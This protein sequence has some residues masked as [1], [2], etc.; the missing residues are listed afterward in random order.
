MEENVKLLDQT[1]LFSGLHPKHR[2]QIAS[3]LQPAQFPAGETVFS[4]GDPGDA[5][6][7]VKAGE[8]VVHVTNPEV[9]IHFELARLGPGQVFGEMALLTEQPRGATVRASSDTTCLVLA[10]EVFVRVCQQL[11]DVTL[12]VAKTMA[13]RLDA[14]NR[15]QGISF[16]SLANLSVDPEA[17]ALVPTQILQRHKMIPLKMDGNMLTMAM[18]DPSNVM[19]F[20]DVRRC[21]HGVNVKPVAISEEDYSS[22]F[23]R[24]IRPSMV[25]AAPGSSDAPGSGWREL[26]IFSA[27]AVGEE[28]K[29]A[30]SGVT[31]QEIVALV[32][33]IMAE[34]IDREASDVHIDC[35]KLNVHVR[36]RVDG[37]LV[38]REQ[39][40]PRSHYR[41]LISRIKI[42]SGMDIADQRLPQDGRISLT[43]R[44]R[45]FDVRVAS[46]PV[47]G[48]ERIAMRLLDAGSSI[49]E[50]GN[51]ILAEKLAQ[52][53]RRMAFRPTGAVLVTGPT[54]SGKTT[55]LYS[56]LRERTRYA[57]DMNIVTVEDPIEYDL[58]GMAQ[59]QVKETSGLTFPV[60][61]RGF[62]R[63]DPDIIMVGETRD[64]TTA[65]IAMEASITG[66]LVLT[67]MHT[68]SALG[69][70]VRLREMGIE[71]YLIA[72]ALSGV[73]AQR[74][75]RRVCP[76][77]SEKATY[78]DS[79]LENLY[80]C[81]VL[82]EGEQVQMV[83]EGGCDNCDQ[84][85]FRG[86]VGV[87]E[88]LQ[89]GES[90][91][92]LVA[93]EAPMEQLRKAAEA[94]GMVT[95]PRYAGFL[96]KH[97]LTV[98]SEVLRILATDA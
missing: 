12:A 45:D 58:P 92:T 29:R 94:Q 93:G 41:P 15:E 77:C 20:D 37:Q 84:T 76:M 9:G 89:M 27:Q 39:A 53:V 95:M 74:L 44:K 42:L 73:I 40:V 57:Q 32:N 21:L 10:R 46:M 38:E 43:Y 55:T 61:L 81:G 88:V 34:A 68:N 30:A 50:L 3:V 28:D 79:I 17:Y 71:P 19:G 97:G 63:H 52:L 5:L 72:N 75:V 87:Y 85:G 47:R 54:G 1:T 80:R 83:K 14:V 18:V 48:G 23:E 62:L 98:P 96:L 90:L 25:A 70:I 24:T 16:A 60:V 26:E 82:R 69:S 86:R 67:S 56:L 59:V 36:Y 33:Q 51:L 4:E 78:M 49:L 65:R 64:A 35:E 8:V 22:Y 31:G 2:E 11:P 7:V 66:H 6:Y 91:R 13:L